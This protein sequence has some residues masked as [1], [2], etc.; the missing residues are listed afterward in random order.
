MR[1]EWAAF[2][3]DVELAV[4][5]PR[6][7]GAVVAAGADPCAQVGDERRVGGADALG[8]QVVR[9]DEL[10]HRHDQLPQVHFALA[11]ELHHRGFVYVREVTAVIARQHRRGH[12]Q[13][14][15]AVWVVNGAWKQLNKPPAMVVSE[16]RLGD[17]EEA[18]CLEPAIGPSP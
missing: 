11:L 14:E 9:G 5:P 10:H 17:L 12:G 15:A 6:R 1:V 16:R 4:E 13:P 7:L 18:R 2:D 8:L 3:E